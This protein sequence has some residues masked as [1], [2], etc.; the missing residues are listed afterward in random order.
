MRKTH[1]RS[2]LWFTACLSTSPV[3]SQEQNVADAGLRYRAITRTG[4]QLTGVS[5]AVD[6]GTRTSQGFAGNGGSNTAAIDEVIGYDTRTA[7]GNTTDF[8]HRAIGFISTA[9]T[10]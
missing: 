7:V 4:E 3:L 1:L 10:G 9:C 5:P 6:L 8:P 2:V